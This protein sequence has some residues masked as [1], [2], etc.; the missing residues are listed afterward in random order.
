MS[1]I[2]ECSS[3]EEVREVFLGQLV[4]PDTGS[5]ADICC[6]WGGM[7]IGYAFASQGKPN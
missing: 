4:K 5:T 3:G 6:N 1:P 7:H 2:L